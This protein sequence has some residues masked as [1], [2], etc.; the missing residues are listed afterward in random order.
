M[1]RG[2]LQCKQWWVIFNTYI[3]KNIHTYIHTYMDDT[4]AQ[5]KSEMIAYN[6]IKL[7]GRQVK[8]FKKCVFESSQQNMKLWT[9]GNYVKRRGLF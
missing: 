8:V 6:S 9:L 3:H 1:T 4:D 2:R 7:C 5:I